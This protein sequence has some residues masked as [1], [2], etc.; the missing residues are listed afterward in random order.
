MFH[1]NQ[2]ICLSGPNSHKGYLLFSVKK[3]KFEHYHRLEHIRIS[4]SI[5]VHLKQTI[6][7]FLPNLPKNGGKKSYLL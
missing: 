1:L 4:L 6:P 2:T 7:I 3:E 5:K